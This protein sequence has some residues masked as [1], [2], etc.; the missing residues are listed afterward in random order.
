M[1]MI[2]GGWAREDAEDELWYIKKYGLGA[3]QLAYQQKK[4]KD[5]KYTKWCQ[6]H[7]RVVKWSKTDPKVTDG[8]VIMKIERDPFKI[9]VEVYVTEIDDAGCIWCRTVTNRPIE[10]PHQGAEYKWEGKYVKLTK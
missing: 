10:D 1:G 6:E 9:L 3:G 5:A 2:F 8:D 7:P 4:E